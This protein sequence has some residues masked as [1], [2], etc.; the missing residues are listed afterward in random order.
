MRIKRFNESSEMIISPD[1]VGEIIE[2]IRDIISSF[3]SDVKKTELYLNE[4]NNFKSLSTK[5]N[6]Q[7]DDSISSLQITRKNL[8]DSNDKLNSIINNLLNYNNKGKS[9]LYKES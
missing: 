2:E 6:D 9:E 4:F 3:E 7:I 8:L 1:R 5:G